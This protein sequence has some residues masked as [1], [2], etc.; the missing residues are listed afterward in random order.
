VILHTH[1]IPELYGQLNGF[2][3]DE[4]VTLLAIFPPETVPDLLCLLAQNS[5]KLLHEVG[6]TRYL[7]V[8]FLTID[9]FAK[10]SSNLFQGASESSLLQTYSLLYE[11]FLQQPNLFVESE[12]TQVQ[13]ELAKILSAIQFDLNAILADSLSLL[14]D[15]DGTSKS[16]QI[17][18]QVDLSTIDAEDI[19]LLFGQYAQRVVSSIHET[20][21]TFESQVSRGLLHYLSGMRAKAI[22]LKYL[23]P[24]CSQQVKAL[25]AKIEELRIASCLQTADSARLSGEDKFP[26]QSGNGSS[27]TALSVAKQ[28]STHDLS[29]S[30]ARGKILLSCALTVLATAGMV[31]RLF[32]GLESLAADQLEVILT[33]LFQ[34]PLTLRQA[35]TLCSSQTHSLSSSTT[36]PIGTA[37]VSSVLKSEPETESELRAFLATA[38]STR[39]GSSN[40]VITQ[41]VFSA[42]SPWIQKYK[43]TAEKYF[44]DLLI[45]APEDYLRELHKESLWNLEEQ[46]QETK[47]LESFDDD[48]TRLPQQMLT[49]VGDHLLSL[50][51]ELES[52]AS[53]NKLQ[54]LLQL[55]GDAESL[56]LSSWRSIQGILGIKEVWIS[57]LLHSSPVC[58]S[59]F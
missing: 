53:K 43:L 8:D 21:Q 47:T 32:S 57:S 42:A 26:T 37:L 31:C 30:S 38:A 9:E 48:A 15:D 18:S 33:S 20:F 46:E 6:L 23:S 2:L 41:S 7:S 59:L 44:F 49:Q 13:E 40:T 55:K 58:L 52:F 12:S 29:S 28:L 22:L 56:A 54:D 11:P 35:V 3:F 27:L 4:S 17:S 14:D 24:L 5:L 34:E 10:K 50:L 16:G 39:R 19:S 1:K 25:V 51:Q 45:S 36:S